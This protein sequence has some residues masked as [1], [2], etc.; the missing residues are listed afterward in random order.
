MISAPDDLARVGLLVSRELEVLRSAGY[1]T[2]ADLLGHF[3]KRHEDRRQLGFP[4]NSASLGPIC[5]RGEVV[6]TTQRRFG[7]GKGLFEAVLVDANGGLFGSARVTCRWYNMPFMNK[8]LAAGQQVVAHGK[9]KEIDGRFFIDHPE[10]E[11]LRED[12]LEGDS[13]HLDR[14]VPVYRNISGIAQRRLRE[15]MHEL[16][17][18]VD[19]ASLDAGIDVGS[20]IARADDLRAVHFPES[21][22][23][24]KAA[25]RRFALEEFFAVQLNVLW[26]RKNHRRLEGRTH[27]RKT[28]L[29]KKFYASLPFDLTGAQKRSI[30][31]I[32][33]D[34]RDP[35]PMARLMQ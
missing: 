2:V 16:L 17:G 7:Q 33:E 27:G 15:L 14:I 13:I 22:E 23:M 1:A 35:R 8:V 11:I 10:F 18:L 5:F 12:D 4:V 28:T 24:A 19:P 3:P 34:M 29:L 25:S 30:R 31:E 9:L 32:I 21:F 26:R 20:G 6:D